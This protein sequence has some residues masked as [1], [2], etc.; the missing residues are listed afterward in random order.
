MPAAVEARRALIDHDHP[1]LS[2]RRQCELLD[3]P[4]ST[5]YYQPATETADNLMLMR[6][7]DEQY[8]RTPFFGSRKLA[9]VLA[10]RGRAVSRKRIQRLMRLMGLQAL[11][12]RRNLSR[13]AP[14]HRVFPYLLR[15]V[16]ITHVDQVWST[17]IT[18]VPL[19]G[20]FVYLTAIIDWYSRCVLTWRLSN[21]L[22]GEFCVEAL[23]EALA[24]G[25][26]EI[27]NTDQGSQFTSAEFT[28]RLLDRAVAVSMDGRG[29]A[30]DNA[31]IER[32]WRTVK[33]EEI[34]LKDYA[35]VD[36]L[37]EGLTRYFLFYN[38]ERPHQSL[39]Y[40]TPFGVYDSGRRRHRVREERTRS[41]RCLSVTVNSRRKPKQPEKREGTAA[42][43]K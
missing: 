21:R 11:A 38:H 41:E 1:E 22:D 5:C 19:R 17:D 3:L 32:L 43:R 28:S 18:Y 2:V 34:Y 4:R 39:D 26:P 23:E 15:N 8:L 10:S 31:F 12:P 24:D 14:G 13:P 36:E 40:Q 7:I 25:R 33:Y 16:D 27:F 20:G 6:M 42:D 30:L 37:K 35:A 29:R 9:K